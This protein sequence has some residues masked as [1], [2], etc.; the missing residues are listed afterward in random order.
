MESGL[1]VRPV[2]RDDVDRL[3]DVHIAS[4]QSAYRGQIPDEILDGL[5]ST[6]ARRRVLWE[7]FL[8]DERQPAFL[9]E[10]DGEIVGFVHVGPARAPIDGSVG[11]L[12]AI[13]VHPK[14]WDQ[15]VGRA[16]FLK[17]EEALR[18][19]GYDTAILWVLESN[20]RARDFYESAGWQADGQTKIEERPNVTLHEVRYSR[21]WRGNRPSGED[22][23]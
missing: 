17:G 15:G 6:R 7:S 9:A 10:R 14:A 22:R 20:R 3:V 4:W 1:T 11:E 21:T 16:L 19:L 8:A 18:K 2:R 23:L 5:E 13:Y 12:Y